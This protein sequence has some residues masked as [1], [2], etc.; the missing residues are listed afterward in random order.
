MKNF[1]FLLV[2][3]CFRTT[4]NIPIK[5]NPIFLTNNSYPFVLSTLDDY[6]YVITKGKDFKI[7]KISGD[8]Y[9]ISENNLDRQ[10]Y[11]YIFDNSNNNYIFYSNKYYEIIYNPFISYKEII[12]SSKPQDGNGN[13][14]NNMHN[15][16]S[17]AKDNDFIIY[18]YDNNNL[19]FSSKSREFRAQQ[20]ITNI[21][22]KLSC[23]FAGGEI[24]VCFMIINNNLN[25]NCLKYQIF[26]NSTQDSLTID[27]NTQGWAYN[28]ITSFG[29]FD[30]DKNKINTK[31]FCRKVIGQYTINCKFWQV[32]WENEKCKSNTLGEGDMILSTSGDFT[33]NNCYFSE[34]NYYSIGG[35]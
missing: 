14:G 24:Y 10:N 13:G 3:L 34:Y 29:I 23:K 27:T 28:S 33:E 31:L 2:I 6:F 21:N 20:H 17:I 9:N 11:I 25:V 4:I 16:G 15:V 18:G 22:E 8:I 7:D 12:I 32:Y 19:I 26:Q 35:T 1:C 30:I 5:E